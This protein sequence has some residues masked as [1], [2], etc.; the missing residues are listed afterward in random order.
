MIQR[1]YRYYRRLYVLFCLLWSL[2]FAQ[3][4]PAQT[5]SSPHRYSGAGD[6]TS[7]WN[8]WVSLTAMYEQY[9]DSAR[10]LAQ[11]LLQRSSYK[12]YDRG[13]VRGNAILGRISMNAGQYDSAIFLFTRGIIRAR[14]AGYSAASL[15]INIG[16]AYFFKGAYQR[17]LE[18]YN[19][20]LGDSPGKVKPADSSQAY[21][22]MALVWLRLGSF[23]QAAPYLQLAKPIIS[24]QKDTIMLISLYSLMGNV[25]FA[26]GGNSE[27][28]PLQ[29]KA[30]DLARRSQHDLQAIGILNELTHSY[31][32][33]KQLDKAMLCN[34][35]AMSILKRYP[36]GYNNDRYH[37]YHNQGLIYAELKNYGYAET[38]LC[39]TFRIAENTNLR[40]LILHM[41]PDLAEV[42]AHNGKYDLAYRHMLHYAA[43]K[44]SILEQERKNMISVWMK[45]MVG[46]KDNAILRQKLR[47]SQQDS[48]LHEKNVWIGGIVFLGI[49]LVITGVIWI[50][51]YQRKQK[52]QEEQFLRLEQ[53]G[54]LNQLKAQVKGEEQE[55][56]RLALELHD[57]IASQ[58]WAIKLNVENVQQH[59]PSEYREKIAHIYRQLD[60]AALE[61][62][63][64]A[65]NLMPDL[66]LQYG[67]TAAVASLCDKIVAGT[68]IEVDFQE[69]GIV[70]RMNDEIELSV[71][72]M[73]QEL[74]QNVLK[75]AAGVTQLLIQISCTNDLLNI[76][77]EDNG[78]GF[79]AEGT[80]GKGIGLS[81][82]RQRVAV[83]GGHFDIQSN[84]GKGTTVY[85]EFELKCLL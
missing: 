76:T 48:K 85:L 7:L 21:L 83:L 80:T 46:E 24:R 61:I 54:E 74:L 60:E 13:I 73:I 17:A 10:L 79:P 34:S 9:P 44:D 42:Y 53:A 71:Y 2:C 29:E 3:N 12:G 18:N 66:L 43:L 40:D 35:E 72:R 45:N 25:A 19:R 62:R 36:G 33:E 31:L 41:E 6:T 15:Y 22:N 11:E 67:L 47:I 58:L 26:R 20:A 52:L 65:H 63:K 14:K 27:D 81:N 16:N 78:R 1:P 4:V 84:P 69:Y 57:G 56:N 23:E 50:R 32:R 51:G 55:R 70:P 38:L 77:I 39:E 68:S 30:L 64:T 59:A 8:E 28:I 49:L 82:I 75:H 37:A 5:E